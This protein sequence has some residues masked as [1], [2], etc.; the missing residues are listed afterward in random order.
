MV[1]HDRFACMACEQPLARFMSLHFGWP[2]SIKGS[3]SSLLKQT[4]GGSHARTGALLKHGASRAHGFAWSVYRILTGR[5]DEIPADDRKHIHTLLTNKTV[6]NFIKNDPNCLEGVD[7][8]K[9]LAVLDKLDESAGGVAVDNS[10]HDDRS[11]S[12][13]MQATRAC[14]VLAYRVASHMWS[15]LVYENMLRMQQTV[16]QTNRAQVPGERTDQRNCIKIAR[17][18]SLGEHCSL[19]KKLLESSVSVTDGVQTAFIPAFISMKCDGHSRKAASREVFLVKF[20]TDPKK[21]FQVGE[22]VLR[23]VPTHGEYTSPVDRNTFRRDATGLGLYMTTRFVVEADAFPD[24]Q[25]DTGDS[26]AIGFD[27]FARMC[28]SVEL[29]NGG[30]NIKGDGSLWS[31]LRADIPDLPTI[32]DEM[33]A[34][35]GFSSIV[36]SGHSIRSIWPNSYQM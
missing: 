18:L 15:A 1:F 24:L 5:I 34:V 12:G 8:K 33:A 2:G 17:A 7:L 32:N 3:K 19:L 25:D 6:Q 10:D 23:V 11:L 4:P 26:R 16:W 30:A 36:T 35:N 27:N 21:S 14:V 29:D 13:D 9:A 22:N 20:F 28:I 31:R